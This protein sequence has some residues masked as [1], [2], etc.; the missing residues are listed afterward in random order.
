MACQLVRR[1]D[2]GR[3]HDLALEGVRQRNVARQGLV[4]HGGDGGVRHGFAQTYRQ[5]RQ[6]P[7]VC[8]AH[9]SVRGDD[10]EAVGEAVEQDLDRRVHWKWFNQQKVIKIL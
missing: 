8:E 5:Q 4:E 7:L 2:L 9:L 10:R 6:H 3:M 1:G